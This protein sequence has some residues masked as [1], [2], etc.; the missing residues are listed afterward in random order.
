MTACGFTFTGL[1]HKGLTF[2][3]I[4]LILKYHH[5]NVEKHKQD[6]TETKARETL[7]VCFAGKGVPGPTYFLKNLGFQVPGLPWR[8]P[9]PASL[10]II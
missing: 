7:E 6:S 3:F 1:T 9:S 5:V 2:N 8:V 10:L 4:L